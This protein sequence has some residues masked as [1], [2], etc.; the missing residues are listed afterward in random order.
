MSWVYESLR[1][2]G[3][4]L[5]FSCENKRIEVELYIEKRMAQYMVHYVF[6][7]DMEDGVEEIKCKDYPKDV[8]GF[9]HDVVLAHHEKYP[10]MYDL[11]YECGRC[12][13]FGDLNDMDLCKDCFKECPCKRDECD[14]VGPRPCDWQIQKWTDSHDVHDADNLV[15]CLECDDCE[16]EAEL[17]GWT[18][19]DDKWFFLCQKCIDRDSCVAEEVT[20]NSS[21]SPIEK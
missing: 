14:G 3:M 15:M 6:N 8:W 17:D 1:E 11:H 20:S 18:K 2:S 13:G 7:S 12:G 19:R 9:V 10:F 21:S 5:E 16:E 4:E